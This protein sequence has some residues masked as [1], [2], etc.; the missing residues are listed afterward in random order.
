MAVYQSL[1]PQ[2]A[3]VSADVIGWRPCRYHGSSAAV[4]S[5]DHEALPRR[6]E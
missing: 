3:Q 2:L 6:L 4:S 5:I 1:N